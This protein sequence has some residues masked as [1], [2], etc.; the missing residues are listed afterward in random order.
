MTSDPAAAPEPDPALA[1]SPARPLPRMGWFSARRLTQGELRLARQM[2]GDA[3]PYRRVR[4]VQLPP[5]PWGAMVPFGRRIYYARWRAA[6]DFADAE[7]AEQGWFI[8]E[9]A[10]V[11]QAQRGVPLA[12]AKLAALGR[13]AYKVPKR[14]FA[15]MSIE[16]QA[17][18]ARKLFLARAGEP[19]PDG[20]D[21]E[22]LEKLWTEAPKRRKERLAY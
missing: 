21:P 15:Q 7:R 14:P 9:L 12:F 10:H 18:V 20:P 22:E 5:L 3:I 2:F 8:H 11:W 19:A 17:E 13:G 1:P 16:A 4:I 6:K